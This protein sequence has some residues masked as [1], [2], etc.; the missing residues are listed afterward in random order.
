MD[1]RKQ[2]RLPG[3]WGRT[4]EMCGNPTVGFSPYKRKWSQSGGR[5]HSSWGDGGAGGA[6]GRH[7]RVVEGSIRESCGPAIDSTGGRTL[8]LGVR[9]PCEWA[10][11][12]WVRGTGEKGRYCCTC[13]VDTSGWLERFYQVLRSRPSSLEPGRGSNPKPPR[14]KPGPDSS[15]KWSS[16][17]GSPG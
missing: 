17:A 13:G 5:M 9:N 16:P 12:S 6:F 8:E 15:G 2:A 10:E 11:L 14:P 7:P 4:P 3:P 1:H